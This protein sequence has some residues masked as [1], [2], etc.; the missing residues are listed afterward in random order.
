MEVSN[1]QAF[2][3]SSDKYGLD[4]YLKLKNRV[5]DSVPK[6]RSE[7]FMEEIR[8]NKYKDKPS[9]L[10]SI[11]VSPDM[12]TAKRWRDKKGRFQPTT[13]YEVELSGYLSVHISDYYEE[14]FS[15]FDNSPYKTKIE[16]ETKEE[17][18]DKYWTEIVEFK[19]NDEYLVEGIFIGEAKVVG[20]WELK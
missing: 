2:H 1:L 19:A 7:E 10:T 12:E 17:A 3:I 4:E 15:F 20:I 5:F 11:F 9:R 6:S 16:C 8:I 13:I 14:C 18:A